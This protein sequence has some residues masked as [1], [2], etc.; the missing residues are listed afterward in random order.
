MPKKNPSASATPPA[1]RPYHHGDLRNALIRE[2]RSLL[3][4]S[5]PSEIS[6]AEVARRVG[7]SDAAPSR[8]FEGKAGLLAAIAAEGFDELAAEQRVIAAGASDPVRKLR[9]MLRT[10]VDFARRNMGLFD[11]M[12]GP[13]ILDPNRHPDLGDAGIASLKIF[14]EATVQLALEHGWPSKQLD[15]VI[16]CAWA[17]EHGLA[18]LILASRAPSRHSNVDV[19]DMIEFS[20]NMLL[21]AIFAGPEALAKVQGEKPR[22]SKTGLR[23]REVARSDG[24][25]KEKLRLRA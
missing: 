1:A 3:A 17:M 21:S 13:R 22:A 24:N 12:V 8:H 4:A 9:A 10:Y 11:L 6:L 16:H 2:G 19:D 15:L 25:P 18:A 5:G 14:A 23:L 7:V 20:I